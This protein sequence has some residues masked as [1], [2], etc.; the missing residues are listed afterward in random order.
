MSKYE[1]P[2]R[3]SLISNNEETKSW[4]DTASLVGLNSDGF[5]PHLPRRY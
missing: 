1:V 4:L 3:L 2:H 5:Q